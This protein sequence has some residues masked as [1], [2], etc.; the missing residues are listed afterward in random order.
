MQFEIFGELRV[1]RAG[2]PV[3]LGGPMAQRLL[4]ALLVDAPRS[5]DRDTLIERLWGDCPPA[6]ATTAL[7]VH[8]SHVRR[9][10]EP[11][12]RRGVGSVLRTTGDGYV[13]AVDRAQI[14]ADHFGS[15]VHRAEER[16]PVDPQRALGDVESAR[17]LW[18]GRPWGALADEGWLRGHVAR[19]EELQ[20]R[21]DEVWADVQLALG[22]HELIVDS[23]TA[24][25]EEEPLRERRWEQLMLAHYRCGRQAEALRGFQ[26]ARRVLIEE[27]GIEPSPAL[28]ALDQAVLVQ[29]PSLEAPP[30]S[31]PERPRHNL[32]APLT[33]L[34]GRSDDAAVTQKLLEASRLVTITGT[35]GCGK[36]RV[37]LAVAEELVDRYDDGVWFVDL[38]AASSPGASSVHAA[39][40]HECR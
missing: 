36:T 2:A 21:A 27:L 8:V 31:V 5:V 18:R 38:A 39:P 19:I 22:R 26:V 32:P 20:R 6:T 34:I 14:D 11:D 9:A 7:Q 35:G 16:V 28:R 33:T 17:A 1:L 13:L 4:A 12:H 29:D 15:L 10:L 24:A 25:V 3:M 30:R 23:L 40:P 37:A